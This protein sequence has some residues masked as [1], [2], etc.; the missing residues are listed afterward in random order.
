MKKRQQFETTRQIAALRT[1]QLERAR[2]DTLRVVQTFDHSVTQEQA[3]A[4]NLDA[5]LDGWRNALRTPSGF[6]PSL[7]AN[8][9]AAAASVHAKHIQA[10]QSMRDAA[11][12]VE[13][14]R[15][16]MTRHEQQA[17]H[18]KTGAE[19]ARR[20]FERERDEQHANRIE[21]MYLSQESRS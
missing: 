17:E 14:Q 6:S 12:R 2:M 9:A 13:Q 7:A 15:A 4:A 10:Q 8:W 20:Q 19:R 1:L 21:D 18:A 11:A 3:V 5:H 16:E